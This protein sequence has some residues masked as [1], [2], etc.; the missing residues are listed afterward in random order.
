MS[1][2]WGRSTTFSKT[3]NVRDHVNDLETMLMQRSEEMGKNRNESR[4]K[5]YVDR[6]VQ[7]ALVRRQI[8]Y[9]LTWMYAIFCLLAGVPIIV[10]A[11]LMGGDFA[12][13]DVLRATWI[14]FWPVAFAAG[15]LLPALIYDIIRQSHKFVGPLL[16]LR[17]AVQDLT[18]GRDPGEITLRKGDHWEDLIEDFNRLT[19]VTKELRQERNRPLTAAADT[20]TEAEDSVAL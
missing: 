19:E 7:G 6:K 3:A 2:H 4:S 18:A 17:R 12:I 16:R 15:V 11:V 8:I 1:S 20:P 14:Q 9:L 13:T 5:V 10:G